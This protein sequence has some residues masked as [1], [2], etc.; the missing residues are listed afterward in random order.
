MMLSMPTLM[1]RKTFNRK[2]MFYDTDRKARLDTLV[3]DGFNAR[4]Q[5]SLAMLLLIENWI[6][7]PFL[8]SQG[9]VIITETI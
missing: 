1:E 3:E 2:N 8:L 6:G 9:I 7:L 5:G 4:M